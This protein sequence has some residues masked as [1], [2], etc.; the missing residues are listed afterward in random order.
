MKQ[1]V[2]A[3]DLSKYKFTEFQNKRIDN[4]NHYQTLLL[5]KF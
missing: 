3:M 5:V 2:N 4:L 1:G